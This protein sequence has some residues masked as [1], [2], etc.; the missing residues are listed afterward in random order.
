MSFFK[1]KFHLALFLWQISGVP[2]S[3]QWS[4]VPYFYPIQIAQYALQH[5]SRFK[6]GEI[7]GFFRA[8]SCL[9]IVSLSCGTC[10]LFFSNFAVSLSITVVKGA[11][12][13]EWNDNTLGGNGF[14]LS[15]DEKANSTRI[16]MN[17]DGLFVVL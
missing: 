4:V 9:G 2:L 6:K 5:Y 11:K 14:K 15:F 13:E 1:N 10:L 16:K 3:T 12:A 7:F 17:S 8:R